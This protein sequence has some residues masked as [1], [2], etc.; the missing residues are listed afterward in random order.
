MNVSFKDALDQFT[1]KFAHHRQP[2][3]PQFAFNLLN[4]LRVDEGVAFSPV[5]AT[6]RGLVES[7]ELLAL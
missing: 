6:A 4:S 1:I 7:D 5:V 2:L 3:V